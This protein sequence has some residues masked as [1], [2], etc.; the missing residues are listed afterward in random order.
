MWPNFAQLVA[1]YLSGT[2]ARLATG[3]GGLTLVR[4]VRDRHALMM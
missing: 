4:E 2:V 1:V 3:S